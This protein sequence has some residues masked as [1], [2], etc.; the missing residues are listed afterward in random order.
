MY[1]LYVQLC[2]L[3]VLAFFGIANDA[4]V[5]CSNRTGLARQIPILLHQLLRCTSVGIDKV[6]KTNYLTLKT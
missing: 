1:T 3:R 5:K 6:T 2:E 4:Q